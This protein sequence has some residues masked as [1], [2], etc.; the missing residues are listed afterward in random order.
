LRRS[1]ALLRSGEALVLCEPGKHLELLE[2]LDRT[3]GN[4]HMRAFQEARL[5]LFDAS[6]RIHEGARY[7]A[8]PGDAQPSES[9]AASKAYNYT[10]AAYAR[11]GIRSPRTR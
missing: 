9:A 1:G 10:R 2:R 4:L 11:S 5:H 8:A 6:A 3:A 7:A